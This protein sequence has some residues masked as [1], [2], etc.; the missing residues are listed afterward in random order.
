MGEGE[1]FVSIIIPCR[2]EAAYIRQCLESVDGNDYPKDRLEV[3]VIDGMSDDGTAEI[4]EGFAATHGYV[5]VVENPKKTTP[6]ALNHGIEKA[7]GSIIMRMDAHTLYPPN[8]ISTLVSWLD[9]SG[10][11]N[12]GGTIV[13]IPQDG[14]PVA[15]AISV[16]LSHRFGVGNAHFR[17][18]I[19]KPTTVDTVPFGCYRRDVFDRVGM[20]DEELPRYQDLEFNLRLKKLGGWILLIPAIASRYYPRTSL[21]KLTMTSFHDGYFGIAAARKLGRWPP[22]RQLTPG[23]FVLCLLITAATAPWSWWSA[24]VFAAIL[25][26]YLLVDVACCAAVARHKG[27]KCGLLLSMVF[28]LLHF[29]RGFGTLKGIGAFLILRRHLGTS[30]HEFPITR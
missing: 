22:L 19:S 8:Y 13:T 1:P 26:S 25:A 5:K 4:V 10:A 21:R 7:R 28:P 29:G 24:F 9:R 3:L 18:G 11:D 27:L 2:C 23:V 30:T 14:T 16:A 15:Q 20:F 6:A 17:L 12:V